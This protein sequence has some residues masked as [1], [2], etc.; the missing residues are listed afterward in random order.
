MAVGATEEIV[1]TI[2]LLPTQPVGTVR[3]TWAWTR[4]RT[5]PTRQQRRRGPTE[6]DRPVAGQIAGLIAAALLVA[7]GWLC[8]RPPA[9]ATSLS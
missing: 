9:S 7:G 2:D 6:V 5:I 4:R 8:P 1:V 3:N